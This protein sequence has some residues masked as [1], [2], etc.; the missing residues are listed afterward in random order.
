MYPNRLGIAKFDRL[1][2]V[3]YEIF[4]DD[5]KFSHHEYFIDRDSFRYD[6]LL[7]KLD[8]EYPTISR[9]LF[10]LG[11]GAFLGSVLSW[12]PSQDNTRDA[13]YLYL[14][15]RVKNWEDQPNVR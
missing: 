3:C 13:F 1:E 15:S 9:L 12:D 10:A 8:R 14:A 4:G 6:S 11:E 7:D 2:I 5:G